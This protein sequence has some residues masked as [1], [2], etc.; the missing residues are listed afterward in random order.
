VELYRP[1]F[2]NYFPAHCSIIRTPA[3]IGAGDPVHH[4][5]DNADRGIGPISALLFVDLPLP[6]RSNACRILFG[7]SN[8]TASGFCVG[9][10]MDPLSSCRL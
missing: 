2:S 9:P 7:L 3:S 5:A 10:C 1:F 6:L 4:A 8:R